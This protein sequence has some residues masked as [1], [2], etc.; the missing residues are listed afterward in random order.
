MEGGRRQSRSIWSCE[1]SQSSLCVDD[2][3]AV[4]CKRMIRLLSMRDC[5]VYEW[6]F[7]LQACMGSLST[8]TSN[9]RG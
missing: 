4:C 2:L 1:Q 8:K 3:V 6:C 5:G 9:R 7:C